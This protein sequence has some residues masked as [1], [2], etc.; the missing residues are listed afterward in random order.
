MNAKQ[1]RMHR[2]MLS[3]KADIASWKRLPDFIKG[4]LRYFH[5]NNE[6]LGR[7]SFSNSMKAIGAFPVS[8]V[9]M[10]AAFPG[11]SDYAESTTFYRPSPD[12]SVRAR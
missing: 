5:E 6:K 3:T 8:G 11:L 9:F 7:F 10:K 1:S 2:Q 12:Q 4:K